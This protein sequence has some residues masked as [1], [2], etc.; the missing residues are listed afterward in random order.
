MPDPDAVPQ[1]MIVSGP[2]VMTGEVETEW[3]IVVLLS[4]TGGN[5]DVCTITVVVP[6]LEDIPV[7]VLPPVTVPFEVLGAASTP[8]VMVAVVF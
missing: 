6:G 7:A 5:V 2:L 8:L 4:V 3:V 1:P